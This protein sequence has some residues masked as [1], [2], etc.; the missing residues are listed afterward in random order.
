MIV[1]SNGDARQTIWISA[2]QIHT[3]ST[4]NYH[5]RSCMRLKMN[6]T[7][8]LTTN[9]PSSN[10]EARMSWVYSKSANKWL[11]IFRLCLC[12]KFLYPFLPRSS[13]WICV[14]LLK[15]SRLIE[16]YLSDPS[17][18]KFIE[19][20]WVICSQRNCE[21]VKCFSIC[22]NWKLKFAPDPVWFALRFISSLCHMSLFDSSSREWAYV[23]V[24]WWR[25]GI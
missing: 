20:P 6:R 7:N 21:I 23:R 24:W 22:V 15:Y 2:A 17:W 19:V 3:T 9:P 1:T 16:V 18:Y 12:I 25:S 5:R 14:I 4:T 11:K 13:W 8:Y 10:S